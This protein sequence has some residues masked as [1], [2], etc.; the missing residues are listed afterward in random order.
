MNRWK[1]NSPS[2]PVHDFKRPFTDLVPFEI[3][4]FE[5]MPDEAWASFPHRHNFYEIVYLTQGEGHHV[6]DFDTYPVHSDS[7][8]FISPRQ[9]HFWQIS[10]S[11]KGWL[12]FFTDEFLSY[13]PSGSTFSELALFSAS[14]HPP[15]LKLEEDQKQVILPVIRSLEREYLTHKSEYASVLRA[16]L[17]ILLMKAY[18][19]HNEVWAGGESQNTS[20]LVRRFKQLV[21]QQRGTRRSVR[22]LA[23]QLR[24]TAGHLSETVKSVTGCTPGQIIRQTLII[25]AKRLLANTD[26]T[27]SEIAYSLDF[28]D[29]FYFSR[30]FKRETGMSPCRFRKRIREKYILF[31]K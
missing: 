10:L 18:L 20:H 13:P 31:Q 3:N 1:V 24:I 15:Y 29:P 28:E 6:I 16:Y 14:E 11:L 12:I 22:S 21:V 19:F 27:I 8:Y 25:E 23:E 5:E 30:V 17:H 7:L 26:L 9:I 2:L 4:S